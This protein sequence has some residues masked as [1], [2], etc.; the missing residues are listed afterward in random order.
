MSQ[1]VDVMEGV[2]KVAMKYDTNGIE[3]R[4]LNSG[5]GRIV[6]VGSRATRLAGA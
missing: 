5:K 3:I 1:A 2:V 6:K 4:F